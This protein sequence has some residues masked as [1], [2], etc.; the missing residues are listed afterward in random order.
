MRTP[1]V[2]PVSRH[3]HPAGSALWSADAESQDVRQYR[4]LLRTAN[5]DALEAAHREALEELSPK[6]RGRVLQGVRDGLVAGLRA[7]A[8]DVTI[9]AHLLTVG[10]RRAPGAFLSACDLHALEQLARAVNVAEAAF[11]LFA[12]Y[13]AWDGHEPDRSPERDDSEYAEGWHTRLAGRDD[14]GARAYDG[15]GGA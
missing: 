11:G 9:I 4:F 14:T 2:P 10:E 5:L 12:G 13:T 7:S 15:W 6:D 8:D 1:H 3:A